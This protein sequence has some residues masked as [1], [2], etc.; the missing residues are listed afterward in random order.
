MPS[1]VLLLS[2]RDRK[3]IVASVSNFIYQNDGNIIT[4]D[5]HLDKETNTFFMRIEWDLKDFKIEPEKISDA[6]KPVAEKFGMNYRVEF[7]D[8]IQNVAI[9]VG[10]LPHCLV[11]LLTRHRTG[12]LRCRI[13][14]IISNHPDLK[15]I[16]DF[17]GIKFYV[18]PKSPGNKSKQEEKELE[19]LKNHN[20]DL[21]VLARY[22]QILS[23]NFVNQYKNRIIN[24]HHSFLPSFAG[25]NPYKQAYDKGVKLIGATAHY[26]TPE[27]D[28]GPIIEQEVV[29]VSHKDSLEDLIRKGRDL[30]KLVLARAVRWHLEH[31]ILVYR[32]KTVVFD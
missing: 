4:S 26:V 27:L 2:C 21:I 24:V 17:Y 16:A 18:V 5:Q 32:N 14:V 10:K 30:E 20:I 13:P 15:E 25:P 6:F 8:R 9:F 28:Q 3:G 7:S 29:R 31:K 11:D 22:M 12:E 1:A 19:I 23:E